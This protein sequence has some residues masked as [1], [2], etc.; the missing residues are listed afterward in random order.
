MLDEVALL[1]PQQV[2]GSSA[3]IKVNTENGKWI[4]IFKLVC[5][6]YDEGA[7]VGPAF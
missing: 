3:Q 6:A 5:M 7:V 1:N 2:K 4:K